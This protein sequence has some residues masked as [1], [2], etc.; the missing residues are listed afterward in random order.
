MENNFLLSQIAN[1]EY[2]EILYSRIN[3]LHR[4]VDSLEELQRQDGCVK[5]NVN[6][7]IIGVDEK[8]ISIGTGAVSVRGEVTGYYET[9]DKL[10]D[11]PVNVNT[12]SVVQGRITDCAQVGVN[13]SSTIEIDE[14]AQYVPETTF[15]L[16]WT[17]ETYQICLPKEA[18]HMESG[19]FYVYIVEEKWGILGNTYM[20][21]KRNI[22][23]LNSNDDLIAVEGNLPATEKT[24]SYSDRELFDGCAVVLGD[25]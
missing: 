13:L 21:T 20:A 24:I 1:E 3:I 2:R 16:E 5:S 8:G 7:W 17:G 23:L 6:G 25:Y 4:E 10:I 22:T 14:M 11:V 15:A 12:G 18:L 19:E 9:P